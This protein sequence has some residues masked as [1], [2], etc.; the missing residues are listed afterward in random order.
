MSSFQ[1]TLS[2]RENNKLGGIYYHKP[3]KVV[4]D[5]LVLTPLCVT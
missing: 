3:R 1:L 2:R 5:F 4:L